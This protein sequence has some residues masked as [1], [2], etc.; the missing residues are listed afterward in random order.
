M[1]WYFCY[2]KVCFF[3]CSNNF[4]LK[5]YFVWYS[6]CHINS[7]LVVISMEYLYI[8]TFNLFP[9]LNLK[10]FTFRQH[11]VGSCFIKSILLIYFF[12][13]IFNL[14]ALDVITNKVRLMSTIFLF[15]FHMSC[16]FFFPVFPLM[17]SVLNIFL[18]GSLIPL[19]L[20]LYF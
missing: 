17:T 9:P 8:F 10:S 12:I 11:I 16:I 15:V 2:F 18:C 13:G 19:F 3:V 20:L 4:Y 5:V 6:H 14:F 1:D 7:L